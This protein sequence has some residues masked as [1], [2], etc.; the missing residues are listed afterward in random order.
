MAIHSPSYQNKLDVFEANL[1]FPLM[2]TADLCYLGFQDGISVIIVSS[3]IP[4][5]LSGG[6]P[7]ST[8]VLDEQDGLWLV[9]KTELLH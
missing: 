3:L 1:M 4:L 5:L 9:N 2:P 8:T 7:P 6:Q